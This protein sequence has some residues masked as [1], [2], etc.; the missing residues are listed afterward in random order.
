MTDLVKSENQ[1]QHIRIDQDEK[2]QLSDIYHRD[3]YI[4]REL[5]LILFEKWYLLTYA[6]LLDQSLQ[7]LRYL[8]LISSTW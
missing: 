6:R 7:S 5:S 3:T 8:H 2:A 1:Y 4:L